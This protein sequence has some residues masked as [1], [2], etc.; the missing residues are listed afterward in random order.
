[1]C[2]LAQLLDAGR[3]DIGVL[4]DRAP[5]VEGTPR[6]ENG[7]ELLLDFGEAGGIGRRGGLAW[8]GS[9][10]SF[11]RD[12]HRDAVSTLDDALYCS[13]GSD[14]RTACPLLK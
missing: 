3:S 11:D 9:T 2:S 4:V 12:G 6:P 5:V 8:A 10:A 7:D 1:M 13:V 14:G